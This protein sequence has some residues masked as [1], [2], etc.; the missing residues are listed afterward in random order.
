MSTERVRAII[1]PAIISK[2]F[3]DAIDSTIADPEAAAVILEFEGGEN[4]ASLECFLASFPFV[5][6]LRV[7]LRKL[8]VSGKPVAGVVHRSLIGLPFEI[9]LACHARFVADQNARLGFPFLR[10]GQLP[11]IGST[12]RLPRLVGIET[13][14]AILLRE[15]LLDTQS[16]QELHLVTL[17]IDDLRARA[18]EWAQANSSIRQ[19]WDLADRPTINTQSVQGRQ[20]LQSLFLKL[21]HKAPPEDT[22]SAALLRCFHDGLERSVDA[23]IRLEAE[24]GRRVRTSVA[25]RNRLHVLHHLRSK[26]LKRSTQAAGQIRQIGVLGAGAM[27]T[28]IAFT[29]AKRGCNVCLFDVFPEALERSIQRIKHLGKRE[30]N[31]LLNRVSFVGDPRLLSQCE[32]VIEAVFEKPDI[33]RA[34]LRTVSELVRPDTILSSNT[35][36]LPIS[37]L[38]MACRCPGNFI[39][40]H[41]FSPVD[42]ME[43]LEIVIGTQTSTE[44]INGAFRL[45]RTLG[46]VPVVVR[47]GPGFYTS[48]VV[49]AYTQEAL[50][51]LR[52]GVSPWFIDNVAQNGG[53]IVGPLAMADL[54]SLDLLL[55]IFRSLGEHGRG[56][57][58][59]ANESVEIL[60]QFTSHGRLGRKTSGGIYDYAEK[61][62]K[63]DW[64]G[65][66]DYFPPSPQAPS[67][68]EI[69]QRLFLI[70][71]I[72]TLHA[73]REN[74]L[75]DPET[76]DLASVLGWSYPAF[77]GGVMRYKDDLGEEQ[78][79][80]LRRSLESKHGARFA[81]PG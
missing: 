16:A 8:E 2:E 75:D 73:L 59:Y 74:I 46:K 32:F 22:G 12:Q 52:E 31:E 20:T 26:A 23:G 9:A 30:S 10:F 51:L 60:Q 72:E 69:T 68:E 44:A 18:L 78:F 71:T 1:C 70:Q 58:K 24:E 48:R 42:R 47:D 6:Q 37:D 41:F 21:R 35:T 19:P 67:P 45:A 39:G 61:D 14:A 4:A 33:K 50:F 5:D 54:L 80:N 65:L 63:I 7:L 40:T 79:Q 27:G 29:A 64:P 38:A 28:G 17:C 13:A 66:K 53:M 55:D 34:I 25:V 81:L 49:A 57:A 3:L 15:E 76:A 56:S 11:V 43:L 77:R 62:R 36:T